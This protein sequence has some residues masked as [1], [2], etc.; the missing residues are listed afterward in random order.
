MVGPGRSCQAG[1]RTRG[2]GLCSGQYG[3]GHGENYDQ[4]E[5]V[6]EFLAPSHCAVRRTGVVF[7]TQKTVKKFPP[8]H[9]GKKVSH[10]IVL[11][12]GLLRMFSS[13]VISVRLP[14]RAVAPIRRSAG[15]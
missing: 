6:A 12:S 3:S 11:S 9:V 4:D 1:F 7:V 5:S 15:S 8:E 13:R 14:A 2:D 10:Q